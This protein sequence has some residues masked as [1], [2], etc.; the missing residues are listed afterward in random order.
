MAKAI[1]GRGSPGAQHRARQA[2]LSWG[3]GGR[4]EGKA[5][6]VAGSPLCKEG[7]HS[8]QAGTQLLSPAQAQLL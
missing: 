5:G 8:S 3:L 7:C 1:A 2:A 6:K 4:A